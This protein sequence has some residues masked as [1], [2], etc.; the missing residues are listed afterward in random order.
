M[1]TPERNDRIRPI[2]KYL[3]KPRKNF[4]QLDCF[5]GDAFWVANPRSA[6]SLGEFSTLRE[7][8][9]AGLEY[10]Q[11]GQGVGLEQPLFK[12]L[13]EMDAILVHPGAIS[14]KIIPPIKAAEMNTDVSYNVVLHREQ[15]PIDFQLNVNASDFKPRGQVGLIANNEG[16]EMY[17]GQ[18][19]FKAYSERTGVPFK[20]V[21]HWGNYEI[22]DDQI[23]LDTGIWYTPRFAGASSPLGIPRIIAGDIAQLLWA[24]ADNGRN[25]RFIDASCLSHKFPRSGNWAK[26]DG[27]SDNQC[28]DSHGFKLIEKRYVPKVK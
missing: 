20:D 26:M 2:E 19:W 9:Q 27:I 4:R 22:K 13:K 8:H 23:Y 11:S 6:T 12:A 24:K 14:S 18:E 17:V 28:W 1:E 16:V 7:A 5:T 3:A 10:L 25:L 15:L 21:L